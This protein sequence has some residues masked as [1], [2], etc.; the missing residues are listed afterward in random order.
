MSLPTVPLYIGSDRTV[1]W[2]GARAGG[3][4]LNSATVTWALKTLSGTSVATGSL[5]YQSGS[6]GNYV[7][8][9]ASS[10]TGGLTENDYYYLEVTL[11]QSG[12][13]DFRR[14]YCKAQYRRDQ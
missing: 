4:Y 3:S 5:S 12:Y 6:N 2:T 14:L 13:D 8:T 11:S 1:T 7:G 9:I 10:V